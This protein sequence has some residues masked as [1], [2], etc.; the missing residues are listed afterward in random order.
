MVYERNSVEFI[1]CIK[2]GITQKTNRGEFKFMFQ[3]GKSHDVHYCYNDNNKQQL[4]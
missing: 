2:T 3:C 1:N 4:I